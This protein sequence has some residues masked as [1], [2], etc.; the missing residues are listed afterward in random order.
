MSTLAAAF[1][2]LAFF[3]SACGQLSPADAERLGHDHNGDTDR[4]VPSAVTAANMQV[5]STGVQD[6]QFNT[7]FNS[8]TQ[9]F[10]F[11]V[12]RAYNVSVGQQVVN[13]GISDDST[14]FSAL[15]K[16]FMGTLFIQRGQCNAVSTANLF[17]LNGS[18]ASYNCPV[19]NNGSAVNLMV[20]LN[21]YI[22]TRISPQ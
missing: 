8:A 12:T 5:N 15:G 13:M 11:V 9:Q 21:T 20:S 22:L 14:L 4:I 3:T 18:I 10:S 1:T 17:G 19:L 2:L 16:V 6:V 7:F